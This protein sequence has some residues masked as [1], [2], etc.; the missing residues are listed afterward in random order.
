MQSSTTQAILRFLG[1]GVLVLGLS[2]PTFAQAGPLEEVPPWLAT[3]LD[4]LDDLEAKVDNLPTDVDLRGV[5]QNWDKQLAADNGDA[6]TGCDSERFTCLWGDIAV[7][8][9]ETGIVWD[10]APA[11]GVSSWI[12]AITHCANREVGGRKGWSLP[13]RE[14][15]ATLVDTQS[16]L[17]NGGGPC[18]PDGHPFSNVQSANYWSASSHALVPTF[19]WVVFFSNGVVNYN[20]K[21]NT[22]LAW[23]VRGGQVYDGQ[24][25]RE[26]IREIQ[27]THP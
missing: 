20:D 10:R 13:M 12:T 14:Q 23:C 16:A 11:T 18:L 21:D 7:R 27:N 26:V 24:D 3:I 6:A 25:V 22:Q 1:V 15:M 9:N 2:L 4:R 17:C 8:D 19:A 5:T